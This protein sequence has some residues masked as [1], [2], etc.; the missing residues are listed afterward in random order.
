MTGGDQRAVDTQ[1]GGDL[2]IVHGVADHDGAASV[3]PVR[4]D[5]GVPGARFAASER[6]VHSVDAGEV[7]AQREVL[8]GGYNISLYRP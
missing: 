4:V 1:F 3:D 6:V 5:Q 8:G 2:G 7:F